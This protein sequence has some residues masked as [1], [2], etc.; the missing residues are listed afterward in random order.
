MARAVMRPLVA[1]DNMSTENRQVADALVKPNDR[2]TSS[3][4]LQIYNQ[5][6]WWRLL[7]C[8]SDDFKGLRSVLGER[9][10]HKLA[11]AYLNECGSHSWNL[12]DLGSQLEGYL[13]EHP[14]AIDPHGELAI[15]MVQVEW[16]RVV[17]FDGEEK[18]P[19]D[20]EEFVSRQP[21]EM[22]LALQPY[23]TLLELHY[24]VDHMLRRLKHA[25]AGS[26]S[27]AVSSER[28]P[29]P[30]RLTAKRTSQPIYMAIHRSEFLV[31][32]KRMEPEAFKI[33]L[34]LREGHALDS[35][36]GMAPW[37]P[38]ESPESIS[39]KIRTW[40]TMWMSFGW[41]CERS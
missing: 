19:L 30:I 38:N 27:N 18:P 11:V 3:D 4:R 12:R 23:I 10:F 16:A 13:R 37:N 15:E 26:A 25:E 5:Q 35:A 9:K 39:E 24:P 17:A 41:L 34:A 32:Y 6:Y 8:L 31:Y 21:A 22:T 1:G 14:E 2:L 28:T 40:F 36:C 7:G 29:R 20:A 33:L